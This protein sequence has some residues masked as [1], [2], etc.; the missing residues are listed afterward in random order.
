MQ[1]A[2]QFAGRT[3]RALFLSSTFHLALIVCLVLLGAAARRKA[4]VETVHPR[5][6][7]EVDI[8]GGSHRIPIQ[9]PPSLISAHTRKPTNDV[10]ASKRTI[11]PVLQPQPKKTGGGSPATPHSGDGSGQ[12]AHGNGSDKDDVRPAFPVFSPR[13]PVTDRALL[14]SEEEKIVVDVDVNEAGDVVSEKLTRGLG[15]QLDQLVLDIV[16][17]WRF[18]P[19]TVNGKPVATEAELIFPFNQSYPITVS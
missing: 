12:A 17:T 16:K 9:L 14:P 8:A 1:S 6:I 15:N 18:H 3:L 10:D 19:A 4:Q 2:L 11:L 7:A 5:L 13:P